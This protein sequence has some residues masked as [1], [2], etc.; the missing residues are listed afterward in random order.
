MLYSNIAFALKGIYYKLHSPVH[1]TN[2]SKHDVLS[3]RKE[4]TLKLPDILYLSETCVM[5]FQLSVHKQRIFRINHLNVYYQ[6]EV[7]L[8]FY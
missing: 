7:V 6:A 2:F 5:F 1:R 4:G 8:L 3:E